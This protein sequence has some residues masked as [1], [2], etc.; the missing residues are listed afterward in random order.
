MTTKKMHPI[1]D[2]KTSTPSN[3]DEARNLALM[4]L[5]TVHDYVDRR[6][7]APVQ[8]AKAL[9]RA[10]LMYAVQNGVSPVEFAKAIM[11]SAVANEQGIPLLKREKADN[12]PSN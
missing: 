2:P 1:L 7:I 4:I 5:H 8:A 11:D 3:E 6:D 10:L 12:G 9:G